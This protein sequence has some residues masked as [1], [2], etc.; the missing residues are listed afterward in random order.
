MTTGSNLAA[1]APANVY[2]VS[3]SMASIVLRVFFA[4]FYIAL[5]T[6]H[7]RGTILMSS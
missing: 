1:I 7:Y 6:V 5:I 3:T 4:L 2:R